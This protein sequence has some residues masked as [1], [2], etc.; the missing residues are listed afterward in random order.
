MR[1]L[2]CRAMVAV[3]GEDAQHSLAVEH[4]LQYGSTIQHNAPAGLTCAP[5]FDSHCRA[6]ALC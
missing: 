1:G 2:P 4:A 3:L 6:D 5:G